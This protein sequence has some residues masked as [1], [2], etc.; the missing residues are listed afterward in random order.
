M[1]GLPSQQNILVT[2][3]DESLSVQA[4]QLSQQIGEQVNIEKNTSNRDVEIDEGLA[5][6]KG[7]D[8]EQVDGLATAISDINKE[9][10]IFLLAQYFSINLY[11]NLYKDLNQELLSFMFFVNVWIFRQPNRGYSNQR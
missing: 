4:D 10:R 3:P 5:N 7:T 8:D 9:V 2:K 11:L 6:S 1:F